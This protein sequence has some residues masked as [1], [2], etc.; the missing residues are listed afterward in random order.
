MENSL[1]TIVS[2]DILLSDIKATHLENKLRN[3]DITTWAD[4]KLRDVDVGPQ[5]SVC[6]GTDS[7]ISRQRLFSHS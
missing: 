5:D 3:E 4:D 6:E 7:K 1:L 2:T